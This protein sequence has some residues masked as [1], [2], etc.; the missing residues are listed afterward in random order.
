MKV[1]KD[2]KNVVKTHSSIPVSG[3]SGLALLFV[4]A[5]I[6]YANYVVFFGTVGMVS[7]IA[8]IPSSLF[9]LAFFTYKAIK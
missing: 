8:L 2:K 9:V 7:K 6:L 3:F 5:S 1:I 4:A